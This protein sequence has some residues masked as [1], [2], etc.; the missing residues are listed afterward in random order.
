MD[1][2]DLQHVVCVVD[3]IF[4]TWRVF[5]NLERKQELSIVS[6]SNGEVGLII[7]SSSGLISDMHEQGWAIWKISFIGSFGYQK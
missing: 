2:H 6:D 5:W 3:I 7:C 4:H 1:S